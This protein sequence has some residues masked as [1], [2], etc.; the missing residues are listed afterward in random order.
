MDVPVTHEEISVERRPASGSTTAS[1]PVQ[2]KTEI[3]VPVSHEEV[4]VSKEPYVKEEVAI[5]KE[6][7]TETR[8]V[9]DTV[10]KEKVNINDKA[11]SSSSK[12]E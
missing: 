5:K 4:S 12:Y 7:V 2:S 6:P 3:K 9:S 8:R 10:T 11:Q 1:K